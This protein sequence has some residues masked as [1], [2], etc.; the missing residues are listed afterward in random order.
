MGIHITGAAIQHTPNMPSWQVIGHGLW[1]E[2]YS[3]AG[4]YGC[5]IPG[6]VLPWRADRVDLTQYDRSALR[7]GALM[8]M[9][10]C[11]NKSHAVDLRSPKSFRP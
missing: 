10:E 2:L 5:G 1:D 8:P 7:E 9:S 3:T 11:C 6:A 4:P